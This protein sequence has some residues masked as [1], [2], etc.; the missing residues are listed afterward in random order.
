MTAPEAHSCLRV[1]ETPLQPHRRRVVRIPLDIV[2][3]GAPPNH[4]AAMF[5]ASCITGVL[6]HHRAFRLVSTPPR[7]MTDIHWRPAVLLTHSASA[8]TEPEGRVRQPS[9]VKRV[10]TVRSELALPGLHTLF[11]I[12]APSREQLECF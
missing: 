12:K 4:R 7:W 3:E 2:C 8:M 1:A 5:A 6:V 9:L 10:P 11:N